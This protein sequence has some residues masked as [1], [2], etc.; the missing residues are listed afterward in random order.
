MTSDEQFIHEQQRA[1]RALRAAAA[2]ARSLGLDVEDIDTL[3]ADGVQEANGWSMTAASVE[4]TR[5]IENTRRPLPTEE[6][7]PAAV[8]D[9]AALLAEADEILARRRGHAA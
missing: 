4:R 6:V 5:L 8:D 1:A 9:R 3:V 2:T 7:T